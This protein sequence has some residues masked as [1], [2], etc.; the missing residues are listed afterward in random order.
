MAPTPAERP[1]ESYEGTTPAPLLGGR[2]HLVEPTANFF[3]VNNLNGELQSGE[4]FRAKQAF[5]KARRY[6]LQKEKRLQLLKDSIKPFPVSQI[7]ALSSRF[8]TTVQDAENNTQNEESQGKVMENSALQPVF[9]DS[10]SSLP[11]R[12]TKEMRIYFHY[13][14]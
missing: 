12:M 9:L 5:I 11:T 10:F 1:H 2:K 3:W 6:R 7:N 13:C 14:K 8:T 4:T